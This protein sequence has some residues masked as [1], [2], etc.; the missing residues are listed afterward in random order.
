MH[1]KTKCMGYVY[2]NTMSPK[3]L[4]K[5]SDDMAIVTALESDNQLLLN[6]FTKLADW[7][8]LPIRVEK[9]HAFGM[10]KVHTESKQYCPMLLINRQKIRHVKEGFGYLEKY[11]DFKMSTDSIKQSLENDLELYLKAINRLY[12]H[13][14]SKIKVLL[15]YAYSKFR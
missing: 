15:E 13:P 5:F 1:E 8:R 12:L 6:L 14:L 7:A 9:C 11:F 2:E 4:F 10:R 3:H